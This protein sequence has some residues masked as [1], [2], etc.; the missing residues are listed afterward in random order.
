MVVAVATRNINLGWSGAAAHRAEIVDAEGHGR[1]ALDLVAYIQ[2]G[3]GGALAAVAA[4]VVAA[5]VAPAATVGDSLRINTR[6]ED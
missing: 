2:D 3:V 4:A 5:A 1:G 6:G